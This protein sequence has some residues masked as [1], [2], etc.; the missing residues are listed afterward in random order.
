MRRRRGLPGWAR[1]EHLLR[2]VAEERAPNARVEVGRVRRLGAGLSREVYYA[3]VEVGD[4]SE[5][6]T[7]LLA[8]EDAD[9]DLDERTRAEIALLAELAKLPLPFE[10][11]RDA[12]LHDEGGRLAV[13]RPFVSGAPLEMRKVDRSWERIGR[14]AAAIHALPVERF[15]ALPLPRHPTRRD[16]ALDAVRSLDGRAE[17][18]LVDVRAWM[19]DHLPPETPGVLLHGDLLGQNILRSF[20]G[21]ETVIDWERACIGDPAY[22]LAIVTRGNR[23]PFG[24]AGLEALLDAYG[25]EEVRR[26]HVRIHELALHAGWYLDALDGDG[27]HPPEHH[28]RQL[29]ALF[30]RVSKR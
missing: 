29:C 3:E 5:L 20:E 1:A 8:T 15:A 4:T 26:S 22:E 17:P 25:D 21:V 14:I 12:T 13:V 24:T 19:L 27:P 11:P 10:I 23:R 2:T 6:M 28:L 7:V 30:A 18:E 16:H 9:P